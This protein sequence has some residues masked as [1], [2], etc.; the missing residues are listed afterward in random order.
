MIKR[1]GQS[2]LA[3]LIAVDILACAVWLALLYPLRLADR[4]TGREMISSYVGEAAHNGRA[5][6]KYAAA[7]IDTVA[8]WLGDSPNHCYRAF[9]FYQYLDD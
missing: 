7:V 2:I 4:P 9:K 5:W 8:C 6:A 1:L 3:V